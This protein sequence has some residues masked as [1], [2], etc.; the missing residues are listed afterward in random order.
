MGWT[1]GRGNSLPPSC[2][3]KVWPSNIQS[4]FP[5]NREVWL[6]YPKKILAATDCH[7]WITVH[8]ASPHHCL[9]CQRD[10]WHRTG[11]ANFVPSGDF[12]KTHFWLL[13]REQ[14]SSH[15]VYTVQESL[16]VKIC[17]EH[18]GRKVRNKHNLSHSSQIHHWALTC[19]PTDLQTLGSMVKR[20]CVSAS[21]YG[22]WKDALGLSSPATSI[23]VNA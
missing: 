20:C 3:Q 16:P 19:E 12:L 4:P 17:Y 9:L 18:C 5:H 22:C 1:G 10:A 21:S 23:P 8:W 11:N 14:L 7:G 6:G 2:S 13:Q 15:W